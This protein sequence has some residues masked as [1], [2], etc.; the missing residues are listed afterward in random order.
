MIELLVS[1]KVKNLIPQYRDFIQTHLVPHELS[2]LS[3]ASTDTLDTALMGI[4][5]KARA[6][7]LWAPH[8]PEKEGGLGLNLVEFAQVSEIMGMTP[9]GHF[10]FNCQAPDIGN[11]ELLKEYA[12][13]DIQQKFLAPLQKGEIRSCFSMTEPEHAGSNPRH[14]STTAVRDGD[15]Y[16]ING[17]KWFTSSADGA[18]F[19]IVMAVTNPDSSDPY[20]K[21]S[22]IVVPTD[23][24]GFD[25]IRNIPIMGEEGHGYISHAEIKY[26]DCRVPLSHLIHEEGQ[27]FML[28]QQRLGPGRIHH[29]MRWIGICER[30]LDLMCRRA[31]E[32]KISETEALGHKQAIQH[33]IAESRTE[34]DAARLL[35]LDAAYK[36]ENQGSKAS[37][38]EISSIK[39]YVANVL[40]QVLDRA[41]QVHGALGIT[42][43][44]ILAWWYR[45]ERGAR[46]YDGPDEVHK[47]VVARSE[48]KKY[49]S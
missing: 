14:L 25:L 21:A 9:L 43:D 15:H 6:A 31:V 48:L 39:Y 24:K 1:E 44:T 8:L 32:R 20:G 11:M 36:I 3:T 41:I 40:Q 37:R 17:H 45:H 42:D 18:A 19:A 46:I 7:G 47:S 12:S 5:N 38:K 34:I 26:D 22:M 27:G 16:V 13:E 28:A 49:Q 30:A 2:L 10:A 4:R 29:C 33:W 23:T 35:V